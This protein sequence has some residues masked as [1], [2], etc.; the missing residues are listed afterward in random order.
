MSDTLI[1]SMAQVSDKVSS[2]GRQLLP[3]GF[4]LAEVPAGATDLE[5]ARIVA[6]ARYFLG[7]IVRPMAPA[8]YEAL[9]RATRLVQLLSAGYDQVNLERL[10]RSRIPVATNGGANAVA[11]AEHTIMLILAV[12]RRLRELDARTRAGGW[13]PQG[14]E[15]EIY[16]L[17]GKSVGLVGLGMI[18]RQVAARLRPF[19]ASLRYF[20][21]RRLPPEDERALE[22]AYMEL[23][24]LLGTSDVISLHVPLSAATVGLINRD[25]LAAMKKGAVLINTCRGEVVDEQALCEAVRCGHL[26]GAGLD[27]FAVEPPDKSNPLFT[28]ANVLVTPHIAGPT[29]DSWRKRFLNG[30]ANIVRVAEGKRPLWVVPELRDVVPWW[31]A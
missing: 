2:V 7:F 18:G 17:D 27:T 23:D 30:Y 21:L 6:Q 9:E 31:A 28:L 24:E 8:F 10:R 15:G 20:D 25:R 3:E 14:S 22:V 26:L 12:L 11:V 4:G 5:A 1:A 16:E 13:R 29:W 19:G